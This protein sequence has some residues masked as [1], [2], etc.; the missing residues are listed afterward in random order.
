MFVKFVIV[1][2]FSA[3]I[4]ISSASA[5]LLGYTFNTSVG[6]DSKE[7]SNP[8]ENDQFLKKHGQYCSG[9]LFKSVRCLTQG[10]KPGVCDTAEVC[11]PHNR[12]IKKVCEESCLNTDQKNM[13]NQNIKLSCVQKP[14]LRQTKQMVNPFEEGRLGI[15]T[16]WNDHN[17]GEWIDVKTQATAPD[18]PNV[19]SI[20]PNDSADDEIT[21]TAHTK[22]FD[23]P[24]QNE[25]EVDSMDFGVWEGPGGWAP[26]HNWGSGVSVG[27]NLSRVNPDDQ[28]GADLPE[29][30]AHWA[31]QSVQ[32]NPSN[33]ID[34]LPIS[35]SEE[36]WSW[37][38]SNSPSN[39]SNSW[40]ENKQWWWSPEQSN[41]S[42]DSSYHEAIKSNH[43][44]TPD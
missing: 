37:S 36:S 25:W 18:A 27:G 2:L 21:K 29:A 19:Q 30:Q 22:E 43:W 11:D 5:G 31:E 14:E 7:L 16:S 12:T 1:P 6:S 40:G 15:A 20:H 17:Q 9:L 39:Q 35:S 32:I 24:T 26:G 3:G 10:K 33:E 38:D 13:G 28:K 23:Q 41:S 4:L 44:G 8:C 34:I 42:W